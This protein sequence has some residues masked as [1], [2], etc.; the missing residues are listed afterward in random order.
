MDTTGNILGIETRRIDQSLTAHSIRLL[1]TDSDIESLVVCSRA[2][3]RASQADD[4][5]RLFQIALQRQHELMT[6]DDPGLGRQQP[7]NRFYRR[8]KLRYLCRPMDR[9]DVSPFAR[10]CTRLRSSAGNSADVGATMSF[11][12]R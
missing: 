10:A 2:L 8:L 9:T 12:T 7:G 3:E 1:A 6:V 5:A 4:T 11:S